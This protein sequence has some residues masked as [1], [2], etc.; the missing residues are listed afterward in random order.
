MTSRLWGK[1][2]YQLSYIGLA[3]YLDAFFTFFVSFTS[4][5]SRYF[6]ASFLFAFIFHPPIFLN[7]LFFLYKYYNIFFLKNQ[8]MKKAVL[9]FLHHISLLERGKKRSYF[10]CVG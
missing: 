7:I 5:T 6:L 4:L 1:C 8:I 10:F 9:L 2:S 3:S